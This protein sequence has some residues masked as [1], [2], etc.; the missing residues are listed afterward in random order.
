MAVPTAYTETS[1]AEYMR[2]GVLRE[3]ADVL[4]WDTNQ[5]LAEAVTDTLIAYGVATVT[6]A[7]NIPRLRALARVAA[8]QAAADATTG[9]YQ[10]SSIGGTY[11]RQQ[12]HSQALLQL[13]LAQVAAAVYRLPTSAGHPKIGI[14]ERGSD[15]TIR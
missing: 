4:G 11:N 8:W 14:I 3:T 10:F 2:V 7:T 12:M 5:P 9:D 6:T 13:E 1:L 15:A